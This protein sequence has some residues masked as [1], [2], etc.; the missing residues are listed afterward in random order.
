MR[1][2]FENL[3]LNAQIAGISADE[4]YHIRIYTIFH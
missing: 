3:F 2:I 1:I 4:I